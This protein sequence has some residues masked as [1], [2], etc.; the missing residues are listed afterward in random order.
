MLWARF[1]SSRVTAT[2]SGISLAT[3]GTIL[4]VVGV[5]GLLVALVFLMQAGRGHTGTT[6][7]RVIEREGYVDP[8]ELSSQTHANSI[9][10]RCQM[11]TIIL[12]ILLVLLL[13]G[14][15]GYSRRGRRL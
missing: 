5:I 10:R 2:V 9:G 1:S 3:V 14:G 13:F 8:Y 15:F 11:L 6:R 7:E 12:I 4:I